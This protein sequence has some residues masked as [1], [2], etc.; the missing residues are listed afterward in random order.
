MK[1]IPLLSLVGLLALAAPLT[2]TAA[3]VE[4]LAEKCGACHGK[5][6]NSEHDKVPSIAGMS[7]VNLVDALTDFQG[8]DRPASRFKPEGGEE[9]DMKEVTSKLS[10]ADMQAVSDYFASKTFV[11][12]WQPGDAEQA[13]QGREIFKRSCEK[14]HSEGGTEADEDVPI[15]AGQWKPYLQRQFDLFS[16]GEREMTKKMRMRFEKLDD[17]DLAAL[18]EYLTGAGRK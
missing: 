2:G 13:R 14:C 1:A 5:D 8:G 10:D 9:T 18:V 12:N 3:D 16:S 6:G 15:L 11:P 4:Q 17:Q 7:A